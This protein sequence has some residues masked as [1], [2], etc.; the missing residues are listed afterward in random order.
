MDAMQRAAALYQAG[1]LDEADAACREILA[2]SG[3]RHFFA[4]HLRSVVAARR[5]DP[6]SAAEFATRALA[7]DAGNAEVLAN[8]G[9]ALRKLGRYQAA[10]ADYDRALAL[11]P[12]A[13]EAHNNRGVAL[14][15]LG[16]YDEALAA[17]A[18]ALELAPGSERA[19][20][21]RGLVRLVLGDL[22]RGL[23]DHEAR[24]NG[25]DIHMGRPKFPQPPWDGEAALAGRTILLHGEQGLGDAI[26]FARYVPLV[27]QR[28]ARV[29]LHVH[30]PLV[31][32]FRQLPADQV[33]SFDE[34]LPPFDTHCALMS[35][36][37][38]LRTTL[39]SIP[40]RV[41]YLMAGQER[42]DRWRSILGDTTRPR[43]GLAWSGSA[44]HTNDRNRSMPLAQLAPLSAVAGTLV[45][46]QKDVR[47]EDTEA[48]RELRVEHFGG[49]L[50]D[51]E[52]TAALIAL[53]DVVVSVDTSA[54]HLA[55]AMA[56]PVRILLPHVPDWRWLTERSD[57]PWYPT[58]KLVRQPAPGDWQA[59]VARLVE[60]LRQLA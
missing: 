41:P 12:T 56:K 10:L 60:E 25:S 7:L 22:E 19:R 54:A 21:N 30:A 31:S 16:R 11:A 15:A 14:A 24:W 26:Q 23:A 4:W 43:V 8:R 28:G 36:P 13:A 51:M 40:A 44:T 57:S 46:L 29:V 6:A 2:A 48:L 18:R 17:Y 37:F 58:A 39:A 5:G 59:V 53:M 3:E 52:D 33:V 9:A 45:S 49:R 32:L 47:P 55:G 27:V 42:I 35:L 50:H 34:P 20:F 1:R 38:A